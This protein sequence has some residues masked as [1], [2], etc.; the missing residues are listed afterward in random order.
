MF[1]AYNTLPTVDVADEHAKRLPSVMQKLCNLLQE[2]QL[3]NVFGVR[4]VHKHFDMLEDELPVFSCIPVADIT[5]V[6]IMSPHSSF[7]LD[8]YTP[9]NFLVYDGKLVPYEFSTSTSRVDITQYKPFIDRVI[10]VITEE[11]ANHVFGLVAFPHDDSDNALSEF[12][13]PELRTTVMVPPSL[14]QPVGVTKEIPTNW[15]APC[16]SGPQAIAA[17]YCGYR[18]TGH[19]RVS[20]YCQRRTSGHT[21]VS[22]IGPEGTP[23]KDSEI[24][25]APG[26]PIA[27]VL[28]AV[29]SCVAVAL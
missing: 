4:L 27:R 16:E 29:W 1:A 17:A 24:T 19:A 6:I 18:S 3:Q 15:T 12:E 26:S 25:F 14:L 5:P 2:Y 21:A 8:Q 10:N 20:G 9:K 13:L 11:N 23:S 28:L 22:P 7:N